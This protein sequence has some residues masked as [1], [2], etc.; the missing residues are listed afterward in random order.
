MLENKSQSY[1]ILCPKC[2]KKMVL[3][4]ALRE[5]NQGKQFLGCSAYPKCKM[6]RQLV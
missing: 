2:G 6:I 3:R 4:T 5:N 1:D